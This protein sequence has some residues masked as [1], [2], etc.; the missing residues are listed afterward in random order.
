MGT[1]C[2]DVEKWEATTNFG[3]KDI[4]TEGTA[5]HE[6]GHILGLGHEHQNPDSPIIWNKH[7]I[8]ARTG[9]DRETM[10]RNITTRSNSSEV[11]YSTYDVKSIMHYNFSPE[12]ICGP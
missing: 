11:W 2:K 4:E 12:E 10:E 5:L 3:W 7:Y 9:W 8:L 6:I 1:D